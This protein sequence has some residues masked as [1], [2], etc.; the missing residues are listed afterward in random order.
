MDW[1]REKNYK[2]KFD[3]LFEMPMRILRRDG[4]EKCLD[5][6]RKNSLSGVVESEAELN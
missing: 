2:F 4:P 5:G 1:F 6:F 3:R